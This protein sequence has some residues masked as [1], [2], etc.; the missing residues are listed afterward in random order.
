MIEQSEQDPKSL[1]GDPFEPLSSTPE[2]PVSPAIPEAPS[3]PREQRIA[4]PDVKPIFTYVFLVANVVIFLPEWIL[5][6][7]G[8]GPFLLELGWKDTALIAEGQYWRLVTPLFL[9]GGPAHVAFNS[10]ALY[11]IG[12]QVERT[13]GYLRFVGIYLLSGVAGV[14]AS[15]AFRPEAK[16]VGASG[17]IFGLLGA[18]IVYLYRNRELFGGFGRRRLS[19]L[20]RVAALNLLLGIAPIID[21]WGHMGGLAGGAALTW[22][23]GPIF[24]I[25]RE[26]DGSLRADDRNPQATHL[27]GI[28]V[29]G[30]ALAALTVLVTLGYS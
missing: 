12:P 17:A 6:F 25:T 3:P 13:F 9:H 11:I 26:Y 20:V 27:M 19:A 5:S 7:T 28:V 23:I 18:L 14:I 30:V 29:G 1:A 15:M 4:L 2:S 8:M 22:L 24:A 21:N 10:Y 16:S